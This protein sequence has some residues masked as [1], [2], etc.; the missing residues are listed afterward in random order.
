M[1]LSPSTAY[2]YT[3]EAVDA[4][5]LTSGQSA[6]AG[7]STQA[8]TAAK[9]YTWNER[10]QLAS[11]GGSVSAAFEYDAFGRRAEKSVAGTITG[12]AFDGINFVQ[13]QNGSGTPTQ[14][15]LTGGVDRTLTRSGSSG[16]RT[17]LTDALGSTLGLADG[18]GAIQTSYTYDPFGGTSASGEA[19]TNTQQYTGRENDGTGLYYYRARYYN[20]TWGRFISEDAFGFA[21]GDPNLYSY[22]SNDPINRADPSG[23]CDDTA[24]I[25]VAFIIWDVG[26]LIFGS[27]KDQDE[28]LIALGLD[29]AGLLIPCA[30]GLG[31]IR[32]A[33]NAVDVMAD[34]R[35]AGR[36]GEVAA[37]IIK[38]TEHIASATGTAAYRIPDVLNHAG[39]IIGEVKNV[40]NL[41]V[42]ALSL[43]T[44]STMP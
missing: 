7:A 33:A 18:A 22:V 24:I 32:R 30:T 6:S 23:N 44:S 26:N 28:N 20:P 11:I 3:V 42:T 2:S 9:T 29:T 12:F 43:R 31:A 36:A 27:R 39:K 21:A 13:E 37:G 8:S 34:V 15:L 25:D 4:A 14:N 16:T 10:N 19:S 35:E 38:N 1:G 17:I 41:K 40:K 5:G